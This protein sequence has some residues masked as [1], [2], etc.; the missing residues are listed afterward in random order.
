MVVQTAT[1]IVPTKER[2]ILVYDP[3]RERTRVETPVQAFAWF[4]RQQA[5]GAV[6]VMGG[7]GQEFFARLVDLEIPV[8]RIP[9]YR[10]QEL[11]GV[12]VGASA[13]ERA[14]ALV[15]AW[16]EAPENFYP[17]AQ[18]DQS[19]VLVR[20]LCRQRLS[21]QEFRKEAALKLHAALRTLEYILPQEAAQLVELLRKGLKDLFRKPELRR[22]IEE[23][24]SRLN[25]AVQLSDMQQA[26]ILAIRQTFS[27]PGFVLGAK[28]DEQELEKQISRFLSSFPIWRWIKEGPVEIKG[29]GPAVGGAIISELGDIIR[30]PTPE[31]LRAY[32]RFHVNEEGRFPHR[33]AGA[34]SSWNRN[35]NQAVWLWSTDQMPRYKHPWRELYDWRKALEMQA[36]PEPVARQVAIKGGRTRT[37][38]DYTL[39]HLDSRA[40]RWTGSQMLTYLWELWQQ[41]AAGNN[42]EE[43]YPNSRWP[44]YFAQA[45]QALT[46][47]LR[48]YLETEIPKRRRAEPA[49]EEV[50]EEG[51]EE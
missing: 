15:L 36:H 39:K 33:R 1:A 9:M 16:E 21:I 48:V 5:Q 12:E 24:F 44:A 11:T 19:V 8:H 34:I 7:P 6:T 14:T 51:D 46:N 20:E 25:T 26:R 41:V 50:D 28:K 4:Q 22:Q 38:Y 45:D 49:E 40:K 13:E 37:V 23:E 30:F 43:W 47:G 31:A 42:P 35:L 2:K 18:L 32:A 27:N 3:R 10:L 17:M 29:F